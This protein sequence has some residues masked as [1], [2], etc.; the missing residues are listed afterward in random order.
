[1]SNTQNNQENIQDKKSGA[2]IGRF[3]AFILFAAAIFVMQY[4][5]IAYIS[6]KIID[7]SL[8]PIIVVLGAILLGVGYG[9]LL[10]LA[11]GLSSFIAAQFG[12]GVANAFLFTPFLTQSSFG[13]SMFVCFVPRILMGFLAALLFK[14]F[15][16]VFSRSSMVPYVIAAA[17]GSMCNTVLV[18]IGIKS[19]YAREFALANGVTVDNIGK[20]TRQVFFKNGLLEFLMCVAA[21]VL[22]GFIVTGFHKHDK[23]V[24]ESAKAPLR[25]ELEKMR[26]KRRGGDDNEEE[27][28]ADAGTDV[29]DLDDGEPESAEID[30][31]PQPKKTTKSAAKKTETSEPDAAAKVEDEPAE[32][33]AA[34]KDD[35]TDAAAPAK[36]PAKKSG[37]KKSSGKKTAD[38]ETPD[39][40]AG[41][42]KDK[43]D[44]GNSKANDK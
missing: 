6:S 39:K 27:K 23:R 25:D 8:I 31:R 26:D 12:S 29:V 9:S 22:L 41:D 4:F 28:P 34:A 14:V 2:K 13:P 7:M 43:K 38:E 10:G 3:I 36:K 17:A 20:L 1:M 18:L 11:F 32:K 37:G 35:K 30:D 40:E 44:D 5:E 33:T 19:F 24:A 42:E 21:A 16:A 15:R